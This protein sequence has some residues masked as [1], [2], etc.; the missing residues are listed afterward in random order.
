MTSA[1]KFLNKLIGLPTVGKLIR[2]YRTHNEI[3]IQELALRL[4]V[5]KGYISNIETGKKEIS[6]D[7]ALNICEALGEVKEIYARVW[8]E[9]QARNAGLDFK[10]VVKQIAI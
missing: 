6:L 2:A 9:E 10:K 4:G 3:S 7:K 8:F 5:T 1:N